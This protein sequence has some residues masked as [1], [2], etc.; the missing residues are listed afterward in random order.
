MISREQKIPHKLNQKGLTLA[1]TLICVLLLTI[2]LIP[3]AGG[4]TNLIGIYKKI[5][6]KT[7]AQ[8]LLSTAIQA[9]SEDL[10]YSD[11]ARNSEDGFI[12]S[13]K[14]VYSTD[15]P[16]KTTV[17]A[18]YVQYFNDPSNHNVISI[19]RKSA[20]SDSSSVSS[21][22]LVSDAA[23]PLDLYAS[24]DDRGVVFHDGGFYT[25][26]ID[27]RSKKDGSIIEKRTA[28]VRPV[29]YTGVAAAPNTED[30]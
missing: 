28:V 22:A 5:R 21:M 13:E 26:T 14:L 11:P 19:R 12:Y 1:E 18:S 24:F 27:V 7:N 6:L 20:Y 2:I 3:V 9:V 30:H 16:D 23:Q 4:A 25:F 10:Y 15:S 17:S 8:T 29:L